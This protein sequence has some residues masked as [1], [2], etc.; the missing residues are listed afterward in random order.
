GPLFSS[1]PSIQF[2]LQAA[3]RN[4][5]DFAGAQEW[6]TRFKAQNRAGPWHDAAAAELWLTN[7][8]GPPPKPVVLSR[9]TDAK[10]F[11]D[12]KLDDAS[13]QGLKPLVLR[14][15]AGETAQDHATEAWFAHDEQYLYIAL[16]CKHPAGQHVP[17]VKVRPRDAD[18]RG[19]DRVSILLDLD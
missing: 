1:D 16:R 9:L 19:F 13:G 4:L 3:R 7:R 2:C 15:A 10:P 5:G 14:D 17:P 11:L 6:Y 12:G 18:L 8:S